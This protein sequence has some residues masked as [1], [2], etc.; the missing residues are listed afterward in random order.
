MKRMQEL[1][2]SASHCSLT[3][4]A[5]QQD[6]ASLYKGRGGRVVEG[7]SLVATPP[8]CAT[9]QLAPPGYEEPLVSGKASETSSHLTG[10]AS[11]AKKRRHEASMSPTGDESLQALIDATIEKKLD[12]RL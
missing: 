6:S 2:E 10:R 12:A 1:C 9:S 7:S 3:S 4:L 11:P 8:L 5:G